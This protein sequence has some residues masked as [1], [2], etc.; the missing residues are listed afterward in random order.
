MDHRADT[1][2]GG[3]WTESRGE[4]VIAVLDPST[5]HCVATVRESAAEDVDAAVDAAAAARPALRSMEPAARAA[6]LTRIADELEKRSADLAGLI[7][8]EMGMPRRHCEGYQVRTAVTT[9]RNTAAA[10][11]EVEFTTRIG[12]STVYREP[13]GVVAAITPWNFPLLQT[14]AKVGPALAAG[15]PVVLKPS[16]ITPLDAFVL[17]EA[18]H[19]AGAPAGA[20]NLVLGNG[21]NVGEYLVGHPGTA[22]VSLT[23]STRAGRRVARLAAPGVKRVALELGGKSAS[24]VLPDGDLAAAAA[25]SVRTVMINSGQTCTALTRLLVPFQKLAEAETLVAEAMAAY[26][27]GM[28]HDPDADVGPLASAGQQQR[29]ND[30]LERAPVDGARTI[31]AHPPDELPRTGFFTGPAAFTVTDP[32]IPLAQQEVFGPL[33]AVI[34]YVDETDAVDI[35]NGTDY[36]LAAAVWSADEEHALAVAGRLEAGSVAVNGAPFNGLAPFGGY[37]QSGHG[38]EL[39]AHGIA[40]FTELK[41]VQRREGAAR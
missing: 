15:C 32:R 40:E 30:H 6:L 26:R 10:L 23:G 22:M 16:E 14:V 21:M 5:G 1:Y 38:R 31:W 35:A 20:F 28:P 37:K 41:S 33:L 12:H 17:A 11:P 36:G 2:I 25:G 4:D 29:V 8:R 34:P 18:V 3:R 13:V 39:G 19:A 9:L 24:V 7:S 27:V